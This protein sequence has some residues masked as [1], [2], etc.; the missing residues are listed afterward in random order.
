MQALVRF[1][2]LPLRMATG[3]SL[4]VIAINSAA[5]FAAHL[6]DGPVDWKLAGLFSGLA[7]TGSLAGNGLSA[8]LPVKRLRQGFAAMVLATGAAVLWQALA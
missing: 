6:G 5:G 1:A 7:V 4:A 3:T 2:R 8:K